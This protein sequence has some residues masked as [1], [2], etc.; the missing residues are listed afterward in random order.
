[1]IG[2]SIGEIIDTGDEEDVTEFG[3][4]NLNDNAIHDDTK[5]VGKIPKIH[6]PCPYC[7]VM[8]SALT[9]HISTKHKHVP[10]VAAA[11]LKPLGER[12][13]AFDEFKKKG[14]FQYNQMEMKKEKP[15]YMRLRKNENVEDDIIICSECK[16]TY[17][18]RYKPRHQVHCGRAGLIMIPMIAQKE[19]VVTTL[20]N[21]FKG[22]LNKMVIDEI[23]SLAKVDKYILIIG[24]RLY[25]SN[26]CKEE[27]I[28]EV[29]KRVRQTMRLLSRLYLKFNE[30]YEMKSI[31]SSDMFDQRQLKHLRYAIECLCTTNE[32]DSKNGLKVQIQNTLKSC[33]KFLEAHFLVEGDDEKANMICNFIKV[34]SLVEEEIFNGAI[35]QLKQKRN[36][37]TRKPANLPDD[38][39][40]EDLKTY[41]NK[42]TEQ[43]Y[44]ILEQPDDVFITVRDAVCAR[45]VLYNG[46]RGGE[47]A[48]LLIYQWKEALDGT[49]I[50]PQAREK[51]KSE[52]D[53]GNRI[54][55]QEGKGDRQ[56]C[57]FFPPYLVQALHFLSSSE[58]RDK[59]NVSDKNKY[60]FP[61][62]Q[63]SQNHVNGWHALKNCILKAGLGNKLNGTMNRHRVISIIG[64]FNLSEEDQNL[65]YEHF[66]HSKEVNKN[67]YQIPQAEK[68]LETTGRL[69][70]L[71][72]QNKQLSPLH[73]K[74]KIPSSCTITKKIS[75]AGLCKPFR[76]TIYFHRC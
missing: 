15:K 8:Q 14:I 39:L 7:S 10:E 67:I 63:Q 20:T 35:Y 32:N 75:V 16:G 70:A 11:L 40:L 36:K 58:V 50:R 34:F 26:K 12:R 19:M 37:T 65:A 3:N 45:L 56:V 2:T 18:K 64:A 46:R 31:D 68:Q 13:K 74:R 25:N 5:K 60:I 44:F 27:K 76:F 49:W 48:R 54:T 29:E 59:V 72:D 17:S 22:V 6:R 57:V 69:L 21:D 66:G 41:L 42:V 47:P 28:C 61:S 71:I 51:Y 53:T 38:A 24:S 43:N 1:M 9:R 30:S 73:G 33:A 55:F 23:S 52:I 4:D 62:T